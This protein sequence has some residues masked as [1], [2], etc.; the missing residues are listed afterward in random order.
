MKIDETIWDVI[1]NPDK[2]EVEVCATSLNVLKDV[3]K[4][5]YELQKN[6]EYRIMEDMIK[7]DA[8][9]LNFMSPAG[10]S[11]VLTLKPGPM[12]QTVDNA[13]DVIRDNGFDP[14][15]LGDYHYKLYPWSKMKEM[16][17]LGGDIKNLIDKLY[18]RGK[19]S[20]SIGDR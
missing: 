17:K 8:T 4:Y 18:V 2:Y 10:E 3:G 16:Q 7:E 13:E 15:Q 1:K 14:N 5:L 20:L 9:K 12:K 11:K 6:V 19:R